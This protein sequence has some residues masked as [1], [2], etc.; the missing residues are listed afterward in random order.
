MPISNP[1]P[2]P[3]LTLDKMWQG[4]ASNLAVEIAHVANAS[5]HHTPAPLDT[6]LLE[7]GDVIG[8]ASNDMKS[9][10]S[11]TYVKIKEIRLNQDLPFCR[12]KI[13]IRSVD[14]G[15]SGTAKV[16]KNG[17]AI[18]A[19][20]SKFGVS[21]IDRSEDF[22]DWVSGD[23][24]QLYAITTNASFA[25]EVKD[26]KLCF[27]KVITHIGGVGLDTALPSSDA[28]SIDATNQDP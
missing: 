28:I 10:Q 13:K 6:V 16:Y 17:A 2:F 18:G 24:I 5:A 15:T 4:D 19:E 26:V 7:L 9:T 14:A 21:W 8:H 11:L 27:D 20:M 12:L 22:A 3:D 25:A 23:L 1:R